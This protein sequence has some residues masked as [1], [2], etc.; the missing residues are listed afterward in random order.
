MS[1]IP[2]GTYYIVNRILSP[3]GERLA[4]TFNG[5]NKVATLTALTNA[6]SQKWK[7]ETY[8]GKPETQ[9]VSPIPNGA[10]QAG[11]TGFPGPMTVLPFN[12]YIW[13]IYSSDTGYT[14]K[15]A[16]NKW[17]WGATAADVGEQ[18]GIGKDGPSESQRWVF[19]KV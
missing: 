4:I 17:L 15:D 10:L 2:D 12:A 3:K 1:K 7:I 11:T 16:G 8:P 5:D 13:S 14:I 18:V 19:T 6:E 9:Y